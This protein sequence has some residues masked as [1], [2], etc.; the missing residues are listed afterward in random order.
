MFSFGLAA[1]WCQDWVRKLNG[2]ALEMMN[3]KKWKYGICKSCFLISFM[4][5]FA[6]MLCFSGFRFHNSQTRYQDR[7]LLNQIISQQL[8]LFCSHIYVFSVPQSSPS[9]RRRLLERS[10]ASCHLS[11]PG[12]TRTETIWLSSAGTR[13]TFA[14][15]WTRTA[16]RCLVPWPMAL[17]S[18]RASIPVWTEYLSYKRPWK[19]YYSVTYMTNSIIILRSRAV[20]VLHIQK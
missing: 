10:R 8:F 11:A 14:G 5:L 6:I 9:A 17:L 19:L 20:N 7:T 18:V 4:H 16:L 15:V 2:F 3:I 13:L 12:V 1:T